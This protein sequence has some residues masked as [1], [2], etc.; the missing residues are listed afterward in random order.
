MPAYGARHNN[1]VGVHTYKKRHHAAPEVN[2]R[3]PTPS[4]ET[5]SGRKPLSTYS[6]MAGWLRR[7]YKRYY[8]VATARRWPLTIFCR[9]RPACRNTGVNAVIMNGHLAWSGSRQRRRKGDLLLL[10]CTITAMTNKRDG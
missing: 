8:S 5:D 4:A 6:N 1:N 2:V 3:R 7:Y 9:A 10:Y